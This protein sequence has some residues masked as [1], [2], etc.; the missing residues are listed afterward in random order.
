MEAAPP[1][2]VALVGRPNVGKSSLLNRLAGEERVVVS[3]VPGTTRDAI[4][5][6][7]TLGSQRYVF[8]ATAG[9]RR[10]GRRDRLAERGS[11]LM[12]VRAIERSGLDLTALA[13]YT[14]VQGSEQSLRISGSTLL[15]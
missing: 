4:D 8:V 6:T 15:D 12:A 3:D 5:V 14:A 13:K 1:I 11:A 9:I 7:L 2:R 10:P